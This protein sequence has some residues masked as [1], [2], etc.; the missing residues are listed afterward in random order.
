MFYTEYRGM[1]EKPQI[2]NRPYKIVAKCKRE[3]G[4][5]YPK[6]I[7][8]YAIDEQTNE[9]LGKC[10]LSKYLSTGAMVEVLKILDHNFDHCGIGS[11]LLNTAE[12]YAYKILQANYLTLVYSPDDGYE[13]YALNLYLSS[14]YSKHSDQR[15]MIKELNDKTIRT[16]VDL[17]DIDFSYFK[18]S[19][20]E[21]VQRKE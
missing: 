5:N 11:T 4:Q 19:T 10:T 20:N 9:K 14:G 3:V 16:Q 15:L 7:T 13:D 18:V 21:N 17:D 8:F 1:N 2:N 12:N 6:N